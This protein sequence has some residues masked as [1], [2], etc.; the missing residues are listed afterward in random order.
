MKQFGRVKVTDGKHGFGDY[1]VEIGNIAP[2]LS[3]LVFMIGWVLKAEERYN[4]RNHLGS[5]LLACHILSV[6][7]KPITEDRIL[8]TAMD[9]AATVASKSPHGS[10][11]FRN[12]PSS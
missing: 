6:M 4:G 8:K 12:R 5:I 3:E 7:E 2:T 10:T 9:A 11:F 1:R